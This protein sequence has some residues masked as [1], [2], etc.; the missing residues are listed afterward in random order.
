MS[1]LRGRGG[2]VLLALA[3][4]GLSV[5]LGVV[6]VRERNRAREFARL[7]GDVRQARSTAESCRQELGVREAAFR[8]LDL[9]VD[10]LRQVV[11]R[12]EAM[13]PRGVPQP[14]Y[15]AYLEVVARYNGA[16]EAWER[17]A[18]A[19]REAEGACRAAV[20]QHNLLADSL[21]RRLDAEGL[22]PTY[23]PP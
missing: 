3:L 21:G 4:A 15:E 7:Q 18:D 20:E 19:L 22:A 17:R 5:W 13:D 11:D 8:R 2:R 14:E 23:D 16:V 1:H 12:F 10:S 9:R 6:L